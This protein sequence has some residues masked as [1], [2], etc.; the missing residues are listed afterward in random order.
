[1]FVKTWKTNKKRVQEQRKTTTFC[2]IL[3]KIQCD[4][5]EK[6]TSLHPT[7]HP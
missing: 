3:P 2:Y 5:H 7:T 4:I 6:S 1:M